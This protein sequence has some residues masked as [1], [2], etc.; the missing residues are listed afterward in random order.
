MGLTS[1]AEDNDLSVGKIGE[2]ALMGVILGTIS[3]VGFNKLDEKINGRDS[4]VGTI[5]NGVLTICSLGCF[6]TPQLV[7]TP[8]AKADM[9][10]FSPEIRKTQ[11]AGRGG[12][13][14][15]IEIMKSKGFIFSTVTLA[16]SPAEEEHILNS[17]RV[18]STFQIPIIILDGGSREEFLNKLKSIPNVFCMV[19]KKEGYFGQIKECLLQASKRGYP[20][21]IYTESNKLDFFKQS[22]K[23]F[24][25]QSQKIIHS[26]PKTGVILA[27]RDKNSLAT[28]PPLQRMTEIMMNQLLS[29]FLQDDNQID[30]TYGPRIINRE[31][32]P[33]LFNVKEDLGWGWIS[34]ILLVSKKLGKP[35]RSILVET[36][37]PKEER[38]EN[39]SEEIIRL[40]KFQDNIFAIREGLKKEI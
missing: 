23:E 39:A 33:Y 31:V 34:F 9:P 32:L 2:G 5:S 26:D 20:F 18:I 25:N 8:R 35:I 14:A 22:L 37:C 1:G 15:E 36:P 3:R 12:S 16:R 10:A 27:S 21:I 24:I 6:S 28:F 11:R 29:Y 17:I 40:K 7:K 13:G 19:K 38:I 30:Y 4:R